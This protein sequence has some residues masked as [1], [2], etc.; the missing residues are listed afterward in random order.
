[1]KISAYRFALCSGA[2][3]IFISC[4]ASIAAGGFT[5]SLSR[6]KPGVER[7]MESLRPDTTFRVGGDPDWMAVADDAVWVAI[8]SLNR[9]TQL[10]SNENRVGI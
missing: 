2:L 6:A 3:A 5:H 10:I 9:V 8:A 7:R 1:M 4:F